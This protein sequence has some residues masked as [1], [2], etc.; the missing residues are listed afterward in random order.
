[1]FVA[2]QI[3]SQTWFE[4]R[5]APRV[6]NPGGP[7]VMRRT[8]AARRRLL[9]C[10]N[11]GGGAVAPPDPRLLHACII[12]NNML[13]NKIIN[14][15]KREKIVIKKCPFIFRNNVSSTFSW[16]TLVLLLLNLSANVNWGYKVNFMRLAGKFGESA[17]KLSHLEVVQT[18]L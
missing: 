3:L 15:K 10:Q 11:L 17:T 13:K 7:V 8:A 6:K 12:E 2:R 14:G 1:M 4:C 5:D 16:L 9:I 18:L